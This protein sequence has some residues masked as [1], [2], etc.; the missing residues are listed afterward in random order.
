MQKLLTG[1]VASAALALAVASAQACDFHESHV[2]A[3]APAPEEG[4]AMS[5][6]DPNT[7]SVVAQEATTA[8]T[9][10]CAPDAKDCAP[11]KE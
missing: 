3:S 2:M 9:T 5:T 4:V 6:Y 10:E 7:A 11:A 8:V 1:I